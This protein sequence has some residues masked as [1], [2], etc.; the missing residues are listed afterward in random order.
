MLAKR[1][2]NSNFADKTTAMK[3]RVIISNNLEAELCEA[4]AQCEHDRIF[5]LT[6]ET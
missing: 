6:D 5:V 1:R 4:I 3:Q 2:K